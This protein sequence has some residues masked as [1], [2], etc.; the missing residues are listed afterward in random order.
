MEPLTLAGALVGGFVNKLAPELLITV[1]L[2]LLL[3]A[4]SERTIKK[5]LKLYAKESAAFAA[6]G[7]VEMKKLADADA[8]ETAAAESAGLLEGGDGESKTGDAAAV[9]A[10][11]DVTPEL[12]ARLDEILAEEREAFPPW[13]VGVLL[14]MFALTVS[15]NLAKGGGAFPSPF[16]IECGTTTYWGCTAFMF[17]SLV[18]IGL[19]V[20]EYLVDRTELKDACGYEYVEGDF[21]WDAETTLKYPAICFFAGVCA[22]LFGIGGGIVNGPLMLEL[23]VLPP[24]AGAT[25]ACMILLTSTTAATTFL[26]FGLVQFDYAKRLFVVGLC[27]TCVGQ[28]G[29]GHLIKKTGRSSYVAFSIGAVVS[30]ST[31]LM[32][33]HGMY[34]LA[35]PDPT[36]GEGEHGICASGD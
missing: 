20:R 25:T 22:G 21:H 15:M 1:L 4:T 5:G 29:M 8:D 30:L 23:G 12:K 31:V 35:Y 27:A 2:V 13:K 34:S 19:K 17:A 33:A 18:A 3:Y 26:T 16:G 36:S 28:L 6:T 24:V 9:E 14:G 7:A 11:K 10:K 32:G